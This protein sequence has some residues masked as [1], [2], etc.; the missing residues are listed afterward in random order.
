MTQLILKYD[1]AST[2]RAKLSL[3]LWIQ[4]IRNHFGIWFRGLV[5]TVIIALGFKPR[6]ALKGG[7]G[8]AKSANRKTFR[9]GWLKSLVWIVCNR[10][11][12]K[13][14]SQWGSNSRSQ[15]SNCLWRYLLVF[16]QGAPATSV[17]FSKFSVQ[18]EQE[19]NLPFCWFW[20]IM[21][22]FSR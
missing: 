19:K 15:S 2:T 10:H 4:K 9:S 21:F 14:T 16:S 8:S 5:T 17:I 13:T 20:F 1:Q 22:F 7:L 6:G 18:K 3:K 12:I 11:V